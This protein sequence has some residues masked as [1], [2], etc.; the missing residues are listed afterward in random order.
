MIEQKKTILIVDDEPDIVENIQA[1]LEPYGYKILTAS[2]G[3]EAL[4]KISGERLD[5]IILDILMPQMTGLQ[6][7]NTL[8]ES[9]K[10]LRNVP[11]ILISARPSM[12]Q[13]FDRTDVECFISKPFKT[14]EII[15]RISKILA[16]QIQKAAPSAPAEP[17]LSVNGTGKKIVMI[18][19]EEY[20]LRKLKN[21]FEA[22]HYEV[23]WAMDED[24]AIK[25]SDKF[26]PQAIFVQFWENPGVLDAVKILKG[27][28]K[29]RA[30]YIPFT[31]ICRPA[32]SIDA[33][34]NFSR[35]QIITFDETSELIQKVGTLL[36]T[37]P[38]GKTV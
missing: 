37:L 30:A 26:L 10:D 28:S 25:F 12:E 36:T 20:V 11:I 23:E 29:N 35:S 1:I 16:R 4:K 14:E 22:N 6:F 8:K 24:Q 17:R 15:S 2:N 38:G 19:V 34:Q 7:V 18:G 3:S 9:R 33:L 13:F 21:W 31:V 32:V 27:V 5:L